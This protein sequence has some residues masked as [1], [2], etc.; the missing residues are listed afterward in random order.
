MTDKNGVGVTVRSHD[1]ENRM[2]VGKCE[3]ARCYAR[4]INHRG[5][6][7]SQLANLA[8]V[9]ENCEQFIK[10]ECFGLAMFKGNH[11]CLV[12]LLK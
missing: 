7:V 10:Y 4:D 1:S 6:S 3:P 12:I 11:A 9:S 5:A 8:R 2:L